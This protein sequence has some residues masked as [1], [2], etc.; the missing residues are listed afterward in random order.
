MRQG[1]AS[2]AGAV[3]VATAAPAPVLRAPQ[4]PRVVVDTGFPR[5]VEPAEG[6]TVVSLLSLALEA[7]EAAQARRAA[8]PAVEAL[9][10]EEVRRWQ[11]AQA[12]LPVERAVKELHAEAARLTRDTAQRVAQRTGAEPAEIEK[13]LRPQVRRLLH[14]Q[15]V[16]LREA[17]RP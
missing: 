13:L 8:V 7:D 14:D 10:E 9:V 11:L 4:G 15:V 12:E 6:A 5:Q 3:V 2:A 16:V 17:V 1:L